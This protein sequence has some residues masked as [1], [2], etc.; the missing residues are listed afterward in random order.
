M[1]RFKNKTFC[2]LDIE[3]TGL[4]INNDR[5]CEIAVLWCHDGVPREA[6]STLVNPAPRQISQQARLVHGIKPEWVEDACAFD[7]EFVERLDEFLEDTVIV[8]HNLL[9]FDIAILKAEY[10]RAGAKFPDVRGYIDVLKIAQKNW[11]FVTDQL[12]RVAGLLGF[13]NE[14]P[15]TAL[16]DT[17]LLSKVFWR[18]M[19]DLNV[20]NEAMLSD[21]ISPP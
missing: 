9:R 2:F 7:K 15:H 5:V 1:A 20:R 4:D 11:A 19:A 14:H 17:L 10:R 18:L 12:E 8:G 16:G 21:H 6:F 13:Y 3:T